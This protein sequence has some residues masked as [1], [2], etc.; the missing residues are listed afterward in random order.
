MCVRVGVMPCG[1]LN[2]CRLTNTSL[3]ISCPE[4]MAFDCVGIS[5]SSDK[6]GASTTHM[7]HSASLVQMRAYTIVAAHH[8]SIV[9]LTG[10]L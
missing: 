5:T 6:V 8:L 9:S 3:G 1:D 2:P 4:C 10:V 7:S